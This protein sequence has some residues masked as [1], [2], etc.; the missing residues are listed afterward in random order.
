MLELDYLHRTGDQ[1]APGLREQIRWAVARASRCA[2]GEAY[3]LA[4]LRANGLG[5][6]PTASRP[7]T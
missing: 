1:L 6:Y 7:A 4:D 2:Y 5:S 3:A